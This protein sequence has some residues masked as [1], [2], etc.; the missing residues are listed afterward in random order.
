MTSKLTQKQLKFC[1]R[2]AANGGNATEAA[3]FAGYATPD[4]EG[5]RLLGN[6]RVAEY[7]KTLTKPEQNN[8]IATAEERQAFWTS[9]MRGELPDAKP[10][11]MIKASEILGKAQGDFIVKAQIEHS[12]SISSKTPEEIQQEA[13]EIAA[14][15]KP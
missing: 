7:I 12:G 4:P 1:E 3:E 10:A 13:M 6:A 9:V 14:R 8:R 5:S 2:Y 11:D 15:L